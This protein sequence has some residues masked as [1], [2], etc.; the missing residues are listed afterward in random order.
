MRWTDSDN[1]RGREALVVGGRYDGLRVTVNVRSGEYR[2]PDV[3]DLSGYEFNP[4][5]WTF[6]EVTV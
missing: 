2:H 5:T 4:T 1:L 3:I 6:E